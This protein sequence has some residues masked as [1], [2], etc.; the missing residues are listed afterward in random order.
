MQPAE[1]MKVMPSM[2]NAHEY[3]TEA[4]TAAPSARPTISATASEPLSSELAA[5]SWL[6]L[7]MSGMSERFAGTKNSDTVEAMNAR[8]YAQPMPKPTTYGMDTTTTARM[9]SATIMVVRRS[10]RST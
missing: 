2:V 5:M 9:M 8:T 6:G 10:Q 4:T 1:M 7:T 3:P